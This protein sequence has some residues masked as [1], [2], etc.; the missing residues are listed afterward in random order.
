MILLI[1]IMYHL[2]GRTTSRE[3][4]SGIMSLLLYNSHG[5]H[6]IAHEFID[7]V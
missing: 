7:E 6:G 5:G 4:V 2:R 1:Q 3:E